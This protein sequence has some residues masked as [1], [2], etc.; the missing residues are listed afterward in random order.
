MRRRQLAEQ[1][2]MEKKGKA[3]KLSHHETA[4]SAAAAAASAPN[5]APSGDSAAPDNV[6]R[7]ANFGKGKP[8][9]PPL[10]RAGVDRNVE[11]C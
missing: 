5:G 4:G 11:Y 9:L 8:M 3:A 1:F 2:A 7:R 6:D 10:P